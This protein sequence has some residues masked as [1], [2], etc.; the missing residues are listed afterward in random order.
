MQS[1]VEKIEAAVDDLEYYETLDSVPSPQEDGKDDEI[2]K[3]LAGVIDRSL[4]E[5]LHRRKLYFNSG[6]IFAWH[7]GRRKPAKSIRR[8]VLNAI[9]AADKYPSC[10]KKRKK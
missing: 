8:R 3:A 9:N 5:L 6:D 1:L 4:L 10:K 7:Y 2:I